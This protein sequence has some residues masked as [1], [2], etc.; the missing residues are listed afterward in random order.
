MQIS[1]CQSA[2]DEAASE[3]LEAAS[4]TCQLLAKVFDVLEDEVGTEAANK[5]IVTMSNQFYLKFE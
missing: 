1:I 4:V 3:I 5:M 2:W